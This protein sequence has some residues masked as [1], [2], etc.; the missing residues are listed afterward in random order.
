MRVVHT[1][2]I[3]VDVGYL[4]DPNGVEALLRPVVDLSTVRYRGVAAETTCLGCPD[5]PCTRLELAEVS[6]ALVIPTVDE[7][8]VCPTEAIGVPVAGEPPE[9]DDDACIGCG[10]CLS[11]CPAGAI[12]FAHGTA[13][14]A[15]R[16]SGSP[17]VFERYDEERFNATRS[18]LSEASSVVANAQLVAEMARGVWVAARAHNVVRFDV[19]V[20]SLVVSSGIRAQ[21]GKPGDH[22]LRVELIGSDDTGTLLGHIEYEAD[23][24]TAGRRVLSSAAVLMSRYQVNRS[25]LVAAVFCLGL[26]NTRVD[27]YRVLA[28]ARKRLGLTVAVVPISALLLTNA[29]RRD[30]TVSDLARFVVDDEDKPD[31][32]EHVAAL[33][34]VDPSLLTGMGLEAAK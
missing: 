7:R 34:G 20:R 15:W 11:R 27:L 32:R 8:T 24:L 17:F 3:D 5:A 18:R 9:I 10:L 6:P 26:P 19:L 14:V 30:L 31:V 23:M 12:A 2:R 29:L 4:E 28:A 25:A 22:A 13:E 1:N 16:P 33:T 21:L